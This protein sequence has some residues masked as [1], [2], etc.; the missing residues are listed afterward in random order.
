MTT[1]FKS[2][3]A[4]QRIPPITTCQQLIGQAADQPPPTAASGPGNLPVEAA[5]W[6]GG[7]AQP[8]RLPPSERHAKPQSSR[9]HCGWPARR[10]CCPTPGCWASSGVI[11]NNRLT[12]SVTHV[13]DAGA[14]APTTGNPPPWPPSSTPAPSGFGAEGEQEKHRQRHR[15]LATLHRPCSRGTCALPAKHLFSSCCDGGPS[16]EL[17]QTGLGQL[18]SEHGPNPLDLFFF[19]RE[20]GRHR[21]AG[22]VTVGRAA[23]LG[24]GRMPDCALRRNSSG[25]KRPAA[26]GAVCWMPSRWLKLHQHR[27]GGAEG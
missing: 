9:T 22:P 15:R 7:A 18:A 26:R 16:P 5:S 8:Q 1:W 27:R 3:T 19:G 10:L 4:Q 2:T 17:R 23:P 24:C 20:V 21:A 13:R 11:E 25:V 12:P 6:S 14:V